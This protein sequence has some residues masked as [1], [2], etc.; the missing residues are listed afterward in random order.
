MNTEHNLLSPLPP[1][2]PALYQRQEIL[3][4]F[5]LFFFSGLEFAYSQS[6]TY[7]RGVVMG[8]CLAMIGLGYYVASALASIVKHASNGDWYPEDLNK[9]FMEYYLFLLAGLML[10]NAVVFLLTA[11]KYRYAN[12]DEEITYPENQDRNFRKGS[13][14]DYQ[15]INGDL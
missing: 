4:F 5:S 3:H 9:G 8:L 1:S 10:V 12:Y 13:P 6:P 14:N 2:L 7:M 11:V 15:S